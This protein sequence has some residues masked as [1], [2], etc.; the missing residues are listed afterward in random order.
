MP[1]K[2]LP[3]E[4]QFVTMVSVRDGNIY[5]TSARALVAK[6]NSIGLHIDTTLSEPPPFERAQP[7]TLLYTRGDRVLRLKAVVREP[8]DRERLTVQP[9]GDVAEGDRRDF[10][11]ADV[12]ARVWAQAAGVPSVEEAMAAQSKR[13]VPLEEMETQ[14]INLSGSGIQLD[15]PAD[16][17]PVKVSD[18][19]D[20]RVELP[21][22]SPSVIAVIGEVVSE[23]RDIDG[24]RRVAV[25]F[26]EI[27]ESDQDLV[28]YTV[29]SRYFEAEGLGEDLAHFEV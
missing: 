11:R 17:G 3:N 7:L 2:P 1:D 20:I 21:L 18:L 25:R 24:T 22:P 27:S 19:L 9:V 6:Q 29:F 4:D 12:D 13:S 16:K 8:I 26:T 23:P 14:S 10:R 5:V 28:V 15:F